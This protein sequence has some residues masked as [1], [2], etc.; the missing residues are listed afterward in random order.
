M[1][2]PSLRGYPR[3]R[4]QSAL[5]CTAQRTHAPRTQP[6][7]TRKI[8]PLDAAEATDRQPD[9]S[10]RARARRSRVCR[11]GAAEQRQSFHVAPAASVGPWTSGAAGS[12]T[13][14]AHW[15]VPKE[16][17]RTW[18]SRFTSAEESAIRTHSATGLPVSLTEKGHS[19]AALS[20]VIGSPATGANGLGVRLRSRRSLRTPHCEKVQRQRAED[21]QLTA[22]IQHEAPLPLLPP[23]S[24]P[25]RHSRPPMRSVA[26]AGAGKNGTINYADVHKHRRALAHVSAHSLTGPAVADAVLPQLA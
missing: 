26:R 3:H 23:L 20:A 2:K 7:Q 1:D 16:C 22:S 19:C 24:T 11:G 10:R 21:N 12:R 15:R 25:L 9:A 18:L 14:H 8:S 13:A 4:A 6:H 5:I 17:G